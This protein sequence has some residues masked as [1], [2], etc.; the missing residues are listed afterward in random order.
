MS[1]FHSS[2]GTDQTFLL[3]GGRNTLASYEGHEEEFEDDQKWMSNLPTSFEDKKRIFVHAGLQPDVPT[4]DQSD[5][6]KLWIRGLFLNFKGDFPK[7]VVH[8]HTPTLSENGEDQPIKYR[9]RCNIDTGA[10]FGGKLTA[11]LFNEED[12]EPFRFISVQ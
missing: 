6:T 2:E 1:R 5:R 11:A 4:M 8:G 9:N 10:V 12:V 3:N 7:Y